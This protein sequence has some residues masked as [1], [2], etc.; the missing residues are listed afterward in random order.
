MN[1]EPR[2]EIIDVQERHRSDGTFIMVCQASGLTSEQ[3][4]NLLFNM[5]GSGP[6]KLSDNILVRHIPG[7]GNVIMQPDRGN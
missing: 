6:V 4:D 7:L 3:F 5:K 1:E 2:M